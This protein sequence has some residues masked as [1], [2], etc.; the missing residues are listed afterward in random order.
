MAAQVDLAGPLKTQR[1]FEAGKCTRVTRKERDSA[2]QLTF[3]MPTTAPPGTYEVTLRV[4]TSD[5]TRKTV[6]PGKLAISFTAA[7]PAPAAP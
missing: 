1:L 2:Q 5:C 7:P 6:R 4:R 3:P